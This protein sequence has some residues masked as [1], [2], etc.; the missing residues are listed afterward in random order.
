MKLGRTTACAHTAKKKNKQLVCRHFGGNQC[1]GKL[2]LNHGYIATDAQV[3]TMTTHKDTLMKS[4]RTFS[5]L[6]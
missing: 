6:T 1:D 4:G 2:H 3:V 5:L